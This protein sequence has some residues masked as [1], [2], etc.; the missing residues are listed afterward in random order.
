LSPERV[1]ED[2]EQQVDDADEGLSKEQ[3]LPEIQWVTHLCEESNEEQSTGVSV[4]HGVH[5]VELRGKA[6]DLLLVLVW[7]LTSEDNDRLNGLDQCRPSDGGVEWLV[8][9]GGNHDDEEVGDVDEDGGVGEPS[10]LGQT[11][12]DSRKHADD[13][14]DAHHSREADLALAELGKV[15]SLAENQDSDGQEL[16]ERLCDVDGVTGLLAEQT[17]EWVTVTHHG[18]ARRVEC[19]V[20]LPDGPTRVSSEDTEDDVESNTGAVADTGKDESSL[21]LV[22]HAEM[23]VV[24]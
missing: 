12:D 10:D 2:T 4:D 17:E 9:S 1:D 7:W 20:D 6:R 24:N 11:A 21:M 8:S 14:D 3:S 23:V 22:S 19:E 15:N 13:E 5:G 16:L 18:V